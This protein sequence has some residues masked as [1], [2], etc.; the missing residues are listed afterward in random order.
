MDGEALRSV[1]RVFPQGVVV[2]TTALSDGEPRGVTVSSFM[3]VSLEPPLIVVCIMKKAQAHA[4]I[5]SAGSFTVNILAEDQGA[6]SDHFATPNLTSAEQFATVP[7]EARSGQP[8]LLSGSVA[9]LDCS[10]ADKIT[11]GT[12]T[13]FVGDVRAG[14]VLREGRPLIFYSRRYWGVGEEGYERYE[15]D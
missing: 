8:P 14:K 12:H 7:H 5:E 4:A 3:S 13:L 6:L 15:R 2:V 10:V 9:Y 11:Q 1:M